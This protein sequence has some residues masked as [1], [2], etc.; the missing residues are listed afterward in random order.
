MLEKSDQDAKDWVTKAV[1]FYLKSGKAAA[2]AEFSKRSGP[3]IQDEM[4][5]FVLNRRGT[6]LA[7]GAD[8]KYIGE[9]FINI[10]DSHGKRFI[11]E[12]V[13]T[14]NSEGSGFVE[15]TW[16]DPV[17][18]EIRPKRLYFQKIDNLIICSGVYRRMWEEQDYF[19]SMP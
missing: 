13:E 16:D 14:A 9:D 19:A 4:Y 7:H 1:A 18:R 6:I 15:Y 3:F 8:E 12:I 11:V 2:L 5:I 17:T 10:Q